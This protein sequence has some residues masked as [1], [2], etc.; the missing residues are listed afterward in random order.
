MEVT[1]AL[2]PCHIN[3]A[4]ITY[5]VQVSRRHACGTAVAAQSALDGRVFHWRTH[6]RRATCASNALPDLE[7]MKSPSS[8]RLSGWP[9]SNFLVLEGGKR[10]PHRLL[11]Q[12]KRAATL[13]CSCMVGTGIEGAAS[14]FTFATVLVMP[15]YAAMLF[16]PEW[17]L[18]KKLMDS[19]APYLT[20]GALYLYLLAL[21]WT[22]ETLPTMFS[23][24]YLLPELSGIARMFKSTLTV[25]SAWIHIL[26]MDLYAA[27]HVYLDGLEQKVP[28]RHSLILCL[29]FGPIGIFCH[30]ITTALVVWRRKVKGSPDEPDKLKRMAAM[31]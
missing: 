28:T 27:R 13:A 8:L 14:L 19:P 5:L 16:A 31:A 15:F 24:K 21:S 1:A 7:R 4:S 23:S 2:S 29:M 20:L 25:A 18:T 10:P 22:P 30:F 17:K 11:H 26:A 6:C 12:Q 9:H 3:S